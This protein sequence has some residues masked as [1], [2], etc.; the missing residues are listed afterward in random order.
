MQAQMH[1][2]ILQRPVQHFPPIAFAS[3]LRIRDP[4]PDHR[5]PGLV[6]E[7]LVEERDETNPWKS[8]SRFGARGGFEA[9]DEARE[10]GVV[11]EVALLLHFFG[12]GDDGTGV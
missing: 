10:C 4:E 7:M 11:G 1:K 12:L 2:R 9:E 8:A 6:V 5:D 3:E